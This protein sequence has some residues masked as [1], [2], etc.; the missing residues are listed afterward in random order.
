MVAALSVALAEP[1]WTG[2]HALLAIAES[3]AA[4]ATPDSPIRMMHWAA[5]AVF[6]S[7]LLVLDLTVFHKHSLEPSM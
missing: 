3:P 1:T 2:L 5:F 6:V 4:S 7:V